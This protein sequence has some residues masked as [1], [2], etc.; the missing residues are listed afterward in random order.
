[1]TYL[2]KGRGK[3][4]FKRELSVT[5]CGK[6]VKLSGLRAEL[7]QRG[8]CSFAAVKTPAEELALHDL[9]Q[10]GLVEIEQEATPS[11]Q[12]RVM[13]YCVPCPVRALPL[14][15]L[16]S[17]EKIV[18]RWLTK[19][20]LRM[21]IAELI[22]LKEHNILPTRDLLRPRNRQALVEKIYTPMNISDDLLEQQM[23]K[24]KCRDQVVAIL[25]SLLK[26]KRIAL[27]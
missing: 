26:K 3:L 9:S 25:L 11:A 8:R 5:R 14:F 21:T 24:A 19:A 16:S 1:M 2:S 23:E 20:G 15:W 27:I 7:W 22:Y 17:D 10:L 13:T 4:N 18:L 6:T 12:Y